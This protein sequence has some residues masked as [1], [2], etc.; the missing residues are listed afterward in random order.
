MAKKK[1]FKWVQASGISKPGHKG[2]LRRYLKR[3][4]L[5]H[6][7]ENISLHVLEKTAHETGVHGHQA[8]QALTM[9]GFKHHHGPLSKSSLRKRRSHM[10]HT[11][12]GHTR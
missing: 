11:H 6:G 2:A 5:L 1:P 10:R 9:R 3:K 8:R 12:H 7:D 4:G